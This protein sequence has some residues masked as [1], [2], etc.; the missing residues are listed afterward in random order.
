MIN[1]TKD[2]LKRHVEIQYTYSYNICI[3]RLKEI[4][5]FILQYANNAS[6]QL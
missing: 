1:I 5:A 4:N 2:F 6:T 3:H